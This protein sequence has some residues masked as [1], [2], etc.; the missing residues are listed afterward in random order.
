MSSAVLLLKVLDG[1]PQGGI[2]L[3]GLVPNGILVNCHIG[4]MEFESSV[5]L[6]QMEFES[7]LVL[8]QMEL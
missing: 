4:T 7:T 2:P 6:R 3:T 1:G 8:G 5:L